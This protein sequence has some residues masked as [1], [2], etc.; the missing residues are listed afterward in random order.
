MNEV[1]VAP[2]YEMLREGRPARF[3]MNTVNRQTERDANFEISTYASEI[4]IIIIVEDV[5]EQE[6]NKR[7]S[8]I[9]Q[10]AGMIGHDIRNPL[11]AIISEL[12]F[13]KESIKESQNDKGST[14]ILESI[15]IIQ[16]QVD[17]INKIV[18]DLQDYARPLNPEIKEVDLTQ[19]ITGTFSAIT[20][21]DNIALSVDVAG[22]LKIR[23]DP[24]FLRRSLTNLVNNAVQAMPEGGNLNIAVFHQEDEIT[25]TIEDTGEGIPEDVKPKLFT[26]L[27]TTKSKGQGF[28]LAVTKRLVESLGGSIDFQSEEGKGTKFI[29]ELPA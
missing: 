20:V 13:A 8:F 15:Q 16:E 27:F 24:T 17:Y 23:T 14:T 4:G 25:I 12:Y 7:L 26:P 11:Q 22:G 6:K 5:T 28:G 10:L 19:L 1:N 3:Q 9:G 21:P 2:F 18:S 29:I